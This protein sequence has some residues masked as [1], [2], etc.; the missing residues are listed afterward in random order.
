[1]ERIDY[2]KFVLTVEQDL[3]AHL[4]A[5]WLD[6]LAGDVPLALVKGLKMTCLGER[7]PGKRMYILEAWGETAYK[8]RNLEWSTWSHHLRRLDVRMELR[9]ASQESVKAVYEHLLQ[10]TQR[11]NL[12]WFSSRPR[13]KRGGGATGGE[14]FAL[15]SH[16]SDVRLVVYKKPNQPWVCESQ[17]TDNVLQRLVSSASSAYDGTPE[18]S[19]MAWSILVGSVS[20]IGR[21]RASKFWP[22]HVEFFRDLINYHG[23]IDD[24]DE[25]IPF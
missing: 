7:A 16:K 6:T 2:S 9:Y 25:E 15:G 18:G 23:P 13:S 22:S 4:Y 8:T 3:F 17:V 5:H 11:Q 24:D 1:M 21:Q 20:T 12:S 10:Q 19:Q 14:G